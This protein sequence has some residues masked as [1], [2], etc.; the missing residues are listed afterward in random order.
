MLWGADIKCSK[1]LR[2]KV[3][4]KGIF[5]EKIKKKLIPE[6]YFQRHNSF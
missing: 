3:V 1:C 5:L 4:K 2:I 6:E